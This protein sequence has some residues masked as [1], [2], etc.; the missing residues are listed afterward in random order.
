LPILFTHF[1]SGLLATA[2]IWLLYR[3]KSPTATFYLFGILCF[4]LPDIDHLPGILTGWNPELLWL[5]IPKTPLDLIKGIFTPRNP[6]LLHNW[7][8]PATSTLLAAIW[9]LLK[10]PSKTLPIKTR[11]WIILALGWATHLALDGVKPL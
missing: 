10:S 3:E 9:N 6:F 2:I 4:M 1:L 8:F 11:H 7:I 5:L